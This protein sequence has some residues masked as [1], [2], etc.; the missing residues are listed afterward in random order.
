MK[1]KKSLSLPLAI[2]GPSPLIHA[3]LCLLLSCCFQ[4][5]GARKYT[6]TITV[7]NGGPWGEWGK[8]EF[9]PQGYANGFAL[10]V[11]FFPSPCHFLPRGHT[12]ITRLS[13]RTSL[14]SRL[15]LGFFLNLLFLRLW[16]AIS[17]QDH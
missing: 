3:G 2:P 12:P 8:K 7:P 16:S 9:C 6:D 1:G 14:D 10:K 5:A 13:A 4:G 11:K 15:F 17:I